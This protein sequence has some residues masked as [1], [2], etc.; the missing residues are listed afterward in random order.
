MKGESCVCETVE[1]EIDHLDVW[2]CRRRIGKPLEIR[3]ARKPRRFK[4]VQMYDLPFVWC[5]NRKE[6]VDSK[7]MR[8]VEDP[9]FGDEGA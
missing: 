8:K 1:G 5:S 7:I 4:I 2:I 6:W 9:E 3:K